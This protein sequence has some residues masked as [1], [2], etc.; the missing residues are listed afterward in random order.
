MNYSYH[1]AIRLREVVLNVRDLA[2]QTDFYHR[3]IGLA[4]LQQN[5]Q[6]VALGISGS[7]EVLMRLVQTD[8]P[9]T[10]N[11]G[12]YHT[13]IL[14][15]SRASLGAS[16]RHLLQ[17]SV[18]L[19]GG[20]DHGYSE[21]IYLDDL[22]KNGIEIYWDK[23][24]ERWDIR[25]D[26]R[27]VG[28]TEELDATG[29]LA[30][31][32][33]VISGEFQLPAGTIIG[34]VHLSV[35]DAAASS[36]LYQKIFQLEDKFS[37]PSASWIASGDYHHHLAFNQWA[38]P[39]LEK[40]SAHQ[41]GL[42]SLTIEISDNIMFQATL[43]RARL[44]QMTIVEEQETGFLLEDADGIRTRVLLSENLSQKTES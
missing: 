38:G 34:H 40:R 20:A 36:K 29:I 9:V 43:K 22:E 13:A 24:V 33:E 41:Q 8:E 10:N 23:P 42:N 15:P 5:E 16:L 17:S 7:D 31:N 2:G 39:Y 4:I 30:E 1:S 6:E 35:K 18:R 32:Q 11:Y 19:T 44:N 28:V 12:L 26:G 25:E 14:L 37:V 21:A 3:M 27:I